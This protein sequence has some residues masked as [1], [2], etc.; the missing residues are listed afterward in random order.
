MFVSSTELFNAQHAVSLK[1]CAL[2]W[3]SRW[4]EQVQGR[5]APYWA[6]VFEFGAKTGIS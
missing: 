5:R 3:E 2:G 6:R 4:K 1:Y